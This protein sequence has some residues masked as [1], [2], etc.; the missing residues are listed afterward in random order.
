MLCV[1]LSAQ[2]MLALGLCSLPSSLASPC[3]AASQ[4][5]MRVLSHVWASSA[6][7]ASHS[8]SQQQRC[9]A[10]ARY[11][12]SQQEDAHVDAVPA[13]AGRI[14]SVDSFS[15]VDGPGVRMVVFEQV[16]GLSQHGGGK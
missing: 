9:M 16:R 12:A 1:F 11:A 15:A 14:H 6:S 5:G 4:H 3:Y 8:Q 2:Q 13:E 10:E 7:S